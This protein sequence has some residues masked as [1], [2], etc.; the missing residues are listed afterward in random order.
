MKM[1]FVMAT[2]AA[3]FLGGSSVLAQVGGMA[4]SP[5]NATSP[6]TI[7]PGSSV[8][9]TGIPLGATE[10]TMPGTSPAPSSNM[11]CSSAGGPTS[12]TAIPLFDGGMTGAAS[13][14]CVGM[15]SAGTGSTG[16]GSAGSSMPPLS[17]LQVGRANIPLGSTEMGSAGLSPPPPISPMFVSPIVPPTATPLSTIGAPPSTGITPP[18]PVTGTF[19]DGTTTRQSRSSSSTGTT[20]VPGC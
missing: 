14:A 3:G 7:G 2:L 11:S 15:G 8:G 5:L 17:A 10:M 13:S 16:T 20:I 9:P 1:Q 18:C 6:L 12:Q 19:P 4:T